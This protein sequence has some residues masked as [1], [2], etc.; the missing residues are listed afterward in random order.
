GLGR[1]ASF[2]LIAS[3][4]LR[5]QQTAELIIKGMEA[6]GL[7]SPA[8]TSSFLEPEADPKDVVALIEKA[9]TQGVTELWLVAHNPLLS[10]LLSL[11][12]EGECQSQSP[13]ATAEI[14]ELEVEWVGL[15]CATVGFRA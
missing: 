7:Q 5:A 15:G 8:A 6:D 3:P 10:T 9:H 4:F 14:V 2:R 11:L 1:S 12:V 13:L